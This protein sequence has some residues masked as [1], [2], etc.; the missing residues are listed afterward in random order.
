MRKTC[1]ICVV[2]SS[3]LDVSMES[4]LAGEYDLVL[5]IRCQI[6]AKLRE[7]KLPTCLRVHAICSF[8]KIM[9]K[10]LFSYG[11]ARPLLTLLKA[12]GRWGHVFG[13]SA[14]PGS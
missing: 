1:V 7:R 3:V 9:L 13:T 4:T 11:N 12:S 10:M 5:A 14:S 6:L 2:A 8:I